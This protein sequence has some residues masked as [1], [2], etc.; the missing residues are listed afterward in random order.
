MV[1]IFLKSPNVGWGIWGQKMSLTLQLV[2]QKQKA[3]PLLEA[4]LAGNRNLQK[5]FYLSMEL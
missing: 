4:P 3:T 5:A 1:E 2:P